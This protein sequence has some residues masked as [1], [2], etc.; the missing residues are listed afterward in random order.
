[1][2]HRAAKR[3]STAK[4]A[5]ITG[6]GTRLG[7][8]MATRLASEGCRVVLHAHQS[9][10]G[11][12]ELA[13]HIKSTGGQAECI[14]ADLSKPGEVLKLAKDA[15]ESTGGLDLLVNNAGIYWP[16]K[17]TD[18]A[19]GDFDRFIDLNLKVPYLLS[20]EIGARMKKRGQGVIV[21][22]ACVSAQ[23]AWKDY[24]PYSISKAGVV[25]MTIGL[26]KLLG[27]EVRVNAIAPGTVLPPADMDELALRKIRERLPLKRL[28][29]PEAITQALGYLLE[30]D[31]VT[32][33]VLYV[34]G[35]R[36]IV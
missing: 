2:R 32:G 5:L 25:S 11:A 24:V 27:P 19:K 10:K 8:A 26:A 23:R 36:S 1:M 12:R 21:N 16:T 22:M 15:W 20:S 33:Q 29:S 14:R 18:L 13:A 35:G 34:D 30:A 3:S 6:A 17:L 4:T 31:F 28:G 7:L 9:I